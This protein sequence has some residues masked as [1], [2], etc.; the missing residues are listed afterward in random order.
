MIWTI[1]S[2]VIFFAL[3]T[4]FA[5]GPIM[6]ALETREKNIRESIE[7]A[8]RAKKEG[9]KVLAEHKAALQGAREETR[10]MIVEAKAIGEEERAKIVE[11]AQTEGAALLKRAKAE[12]GVEEAAAIQRVREEAVDLALGAA[13]RLL[14]RSLN[15]SD[16][17]NMVED[18]IKQVSA[19]KKP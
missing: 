2:F 17:R 1:V 9:E 7:S 18:F 3:L 8:E 12:L 14:E 5:W 10:K 19:G 11:K 13:S 6:K 16:H 4:K 15:D